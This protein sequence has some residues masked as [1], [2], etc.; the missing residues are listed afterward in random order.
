MTYAWVKERKYKKFRKPDDLEYFTLKIWLPATT[1]ILKSVL[2]LKTFT[3]A[4]ERITQTGISLLFSTS[5]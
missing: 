4:Y 2:I 1:K 5:R 3:H